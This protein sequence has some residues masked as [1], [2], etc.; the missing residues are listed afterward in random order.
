MF[1]LYYD[2]DNPLNVKEI[3]LALSMSPEEA[4]ALL[5]RAYDLLRPALEA[6]EQRF[7]V[8]EPSAGSVRVTGT[9][10]VLN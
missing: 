7:A 6:N 9:S 2:I 3:A 4:Q 5:H 8:W 10:R 1:A